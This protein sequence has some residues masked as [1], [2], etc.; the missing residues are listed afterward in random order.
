MTSAPASASSCLNIPPNPDCNLYL[1]YYLYQIT[2]RENDF[3]VFGEVDSESFFVE[4][5]LSE[6]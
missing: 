3:S 6:L 5:I 2:F 1:Y 4:I